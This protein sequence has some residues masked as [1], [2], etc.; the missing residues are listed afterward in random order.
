[1]KRGRYDFD[2]SCTLEY[3]FGTTNHHDFDN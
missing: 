3:M 2:K 1:L